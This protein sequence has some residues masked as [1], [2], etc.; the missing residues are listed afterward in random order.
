MRHPTFRHRIEYLGFRL[1]LGVLRMLPERLALG[2]GG[3][4]GWFAGTV[5]GIRR[6]VVREHLRLAFPGETEAWRRRLGRASFRHLGREALATFL[7]GRMASEEILKRTEIGSLDLLR[8]AL[9]RGKGAVLL[10]AHFGNWELAGAAR[11]LRGVPMDVVA[12]RQRNPLFDSHLNEGRRR[13]GMRVIPRNE[14]PRR[15]VRSLRDGRAVAFVGDQ[16][17]RR[18]GVFV[19]FFGKKA[20]TAR[21]P[22]VFALRTGCP[23]FQGVNRRL[24]GYPTRY[25]LEI[26]PVDFAPTGDTEE[27]VHRL[28]QRHAAFLEKE[29]REG[30]EQYFWQHR[31][32]KTRPPG[33]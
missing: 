25:R 23:I 29:I 10:T 7:L 12:Q 1:A 15:V 30:P 27:D 13:M 31:R 2:M 6:R 33:E 21:G 14:A 20:S 4:F 5:L 18:G 22:A 19:A 24:P 26:V 32:W 3:G 16:N 28:T 9:A 17:V 8:E 11:A